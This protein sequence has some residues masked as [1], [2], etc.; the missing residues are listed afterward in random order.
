[1]PIAADGKMVKMSIVPCECKNGMT[2]PR[3]GPLF[4]AMLN[5]SS[6]KHT[7]SI[8][9]DES[10][11]SGKSSKN[12]RFVSVG[13]DTISF[14]LLIDGTGVVEPAKAKT[15]VAA[16]VDQL[17]RVVHRYEGEE[18]QPKVVRVLWGTLIFFGRLQSLTLDYTLFKPSG[19]PLRVK[20]DLSFIGTMSAKEEALVAK[21]SSPDL[22]HEVSF[23]AG[24]SLPLLCQKIYGDSAYY[25][26]IARHN[27]IV[28][29]RSIPP[30][31]T[32][33]FPPLR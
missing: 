2:K 13:N 19:D 20:A 11:A 32:I 8:Q 17:R 4:E 22:T 18:H 14:A 3:T 21:R 7:Q 9:Y 27:R 5:P 29:F 6:L 10:K 31:T 16:R 15:S 25:T 28:N 24:D 26:A 12:V 1:M 23:K 30:G 33:F